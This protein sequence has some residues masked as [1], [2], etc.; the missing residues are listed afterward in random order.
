MRGL[1]ALFVVFLGLSLSQCGGLSTSGSG[2]SGN[3]QG[4]TNTNSNCR[5]SNLDD[6]NSGSSGKSIRMEWGEYKNHI[7]G[8][9][10][11]QY[12]EGFV[13]TG[14]DDRS[15]FCFSNNLWRERDIA[16]TLF[17]LNCRKASYNV[18]QS[19]NDQP[20]AI[21]SFRLKI[22]KNN[23]DGDA[24]DSVTF[25]GASVKTA[26]LE[27]NTST[28]QPV[29]SNKVTSTFGEGCSLNHANAVGFDQ[30]VDGEERIMTSLQLFDEYDIC[31]T[32]V[33][34]N[35]R[36]YNCRAYLNSGKLWVSGLIP[37]AS[38]S[39]KYQFDYVPTTAPNAVTFGAVDYDSVADADVIRTP[40]FGAHA[41]DSGDVLS[42]YPERV[43]IGLCIRGYK[44]R[45][46][47]DITTRRNL[48][49]G[50]KIRTH[51]PQLTE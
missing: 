33:G 2:N 10:A 14:T 15:N 30:S 11:S 47:A 13:P 23:N 6:C 8:L 21:Q 9:A 50:A 39:V 35:I 22:A 37:F 31:R 36:D 4:T 24:Y 26:V 7:S 43:I 18:R 49:I 45:K 44:Q 38:N 3:T 46:S 16:G 42:R 5:V 41:N 51:R 28:G 48:F 29:F 20:V 32:S 27:F 19:I 1:Y 34:G 25:Q 40:Q 17:N 12:I